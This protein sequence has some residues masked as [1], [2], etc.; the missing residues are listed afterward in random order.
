[1]ENK[2]PVAMSN[3]HIH[4]SKGDLDVLFGKGYELTNVKDLSQPGQYAC[5][6]KVDIVGRKILLRVSEY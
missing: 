6:E 2:V 1:M 3:R 4:V 5:D